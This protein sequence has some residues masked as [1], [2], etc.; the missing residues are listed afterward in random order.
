MRVA[1]E[2]DVRVQVLQKS[3]YYCW[4]LLYVHVVVVVMNIAGGSLQWLT[5]PTSNPVLVIKLKC[6]PSYDGRLPEHLAMRYILSTGII[7]Q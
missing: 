7:S 4:L 3:P 2:V 1:N 6:I 5:I